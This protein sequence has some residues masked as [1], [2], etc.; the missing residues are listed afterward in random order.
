MSLTGGAPGFRTL[1]IIRQ[2]AQ[3]TYTIYGV[4]ITTFGS[5]PQRWH[6][7][8]TARRSRFSVMGVGFAMCGDQP[9][10]TGEY[11]Y[12]SDR[13]SV[14]TVS[15]SVA[16]ISVATPPLLADSDLALWRIK[17]EHAKRAR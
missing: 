15:N 13:A 10:D 7:S 6:G 17:G 5:C 14:R 3:R 16:T 12:R 2:V 1:H 11:L 4:R 8:I 9:A